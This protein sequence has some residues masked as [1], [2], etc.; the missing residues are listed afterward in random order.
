MQ[1]PY[2]DRIHSPEDVKKLNE[3]QLNL[4]CTDIRA[5]L[6]RS[7]SKT[8]GHLASNL[9]VVELTVALH[10]VLHSPFDQ[11]FW[12][13]GHQSYV[14]KL[15]TGRKEGFARLRMKDGLS[16]YPMPRES[17]HDCFIAGHSSTSISAALGAAQANKLKGDPHTAVAVI[18]DGSLTGGEAYEA[19]NNAGKSG[20]RLIVVLNHN[21]M[22]ISQNVGAFAG[23]LSYLRAG[24]V[25]NDIK[26]G[27]SDKLQNGKNISK[28]TAS[29]L[30]KIKRSLK[31]F[32][33]QNTF[34]EDMGFTYLGPIDG[35]DLQQVCHVLQLAK[36]LARP[37]VVH[38]ITTKG[39]GYAPAE[40]DPNLYHGVSK[41][42]FWQGDCNT[43]EDNFSCEMGNTL[44]EL[45]KK[46][47]KLVAITAAMTD[48]TGLAAFAKKYPNRF[49]DVGIAEQHAVVFSGGLT[50]RGML[51][52]FAVYSSFLQRGYDQLLN[53]CA[54]NRCR[55]VLCIDRA[56][57]V[58]ADGET[59]QGLF[60]VAFL[61][62]IPNVT[63]L[64]PANYEQLRECLRD[65]VCTLQSV[66][67]VRYPK[68]KP[69]GAVPKLPLLEKGDGY[70]YYA[71]RNAPAKKLLCSYGRCFESCVLAEAPDTDLLQLVR[72]KPLP[73][74][75]LALL[76]SYDE[77]YFAEEGI[78]NGGIGEQI[79]LYLLE[80]SYQGKFRLRAVNDCF[81]S[82][83]SIAEQ[84]R[85]FGLCS[86]QLVAFVSGA[87]D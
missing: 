76:F 27:V 4:L 51:P 1:Y 44:I 74:R 78:Q 34:F 77:V 87:D 56:G 25:Y 62:S 10:K 71:Q 33:Y 7:V 69:F 72:I 55:M 15:L 41:F 29:L 42:N 58:G 16:G 28:L 21:E 31:G 54:R 52:V 38:V 11:I 46:Q 37:V 82:Q 53:D 64:S 83:G 80:H 65:A 63:V 35:H 70:F 61:S 2:L 26:Q 3:R 59:H 45:A 66:V 48:G 79:G 67:A 43:D 81:V 17:V 30:T 85:E 5:F 39:K 49:F 32:I 23:Y 9:G 40:D 75:A 36:Q 6:I 13:V 47:P 60:D 68:G 14:H 8:G 22:S 12:D 20:A 57:F 18:G 50:S 73:Q 84:M 24:K 19:L 86:D